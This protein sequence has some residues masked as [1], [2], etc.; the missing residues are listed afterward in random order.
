M[1][2]AGFVGRNLIRNRRRTVSTVSAIAIAFVLFGTLISLPSFFDSILLSVKASTRVVCHNSV[3][4]LYPLPEAY[5]EKVRSRPHVMAADG[6]TFFDGVYDNPRNQFPNVATDTQGLLLVWPDWGISPEAAREF[7]RVRIACLVGPALLTRFNWH[8]GQQ[9]ML[10]GTQRPV[11]ITLLIVGTLSSRWAPT[12]LLF[13]RDYLEEVLGRP[14]LVNMITMRV[15]T[16]SSV[17][18][19]MSQI[20]ETF[21][22]SDAETETESEEAFDQSM[23]ASY[24]GLLVWGKLFGIVSILAVVLV[25]ANTAAMSI[26][27]RRREVAVLRSLGFS[28]VKILLVLV[29]ESIA[30]SLAGGLIGISCAYLALNLMTLGAVAMGGLGIFQMQPAIVP[31]SIVLAVL[32]GLLSGLLPSLLILR[33]NI[34]NALRLT[35]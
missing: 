7:E 11:K 35:T 4:L 10:R 30:I 12:L 23:F 15:D 16:L 28:R 2:L 34:V 33:G 29:S 26:R 17:P 25:A 5:V 31:Q 20:D 19:V 1:N 13:R 18:S 8:V 3:G 6:W 14:G 27:E 22:N 24:R 9:I 21:A 32:I